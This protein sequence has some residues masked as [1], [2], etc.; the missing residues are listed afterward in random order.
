M[1]RFLLTLLCLIV[2]FPCAQVYA[3]DTKS[4]M[5][6]RK[7]T[8]TTS[9]QYKLIHSDEIFLDEKGFLRDEFLAYGVAMGSAWGDVGSKYTITLDNG[10]S[11][12]VIKVEEKSDLHTDSTNTYDPFGGIIEF[13]I[14]TKSDWMI[15]NTWSNG[16]IFQ[17]S[18]NN[19]EDFKGEIVSV[20]EWVNPF[21][22][23]DYR[24][25]M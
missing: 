17:G 13:V 7:I 16:L 20:E 25:E 1:K 6:Y 10:I 4:Y 21:D 9:P 12:D 11:F 24:S 3:T 22:K 14:D 5:D 23:F 15:S 2:I 18:F 8:D 19:C